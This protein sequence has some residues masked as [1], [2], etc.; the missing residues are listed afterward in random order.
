M[1]NET[2]KIYDAYC[3]VRFN[4]GSLNRYKIDYFADDNEQRY[5]IVKNEDVNIWAKYKILLSYD[6]LSKEIL[7]GDKMWLIPKDVVAN[8]KDLRKL[9]EFKNK[10]ESIDEICMKAAIKLK[11]KGIVYDNKKDIKVCIL[12]T[13]VVRS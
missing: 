9:K 8:T 7:W 1:S 6:V 5:I 12:I 2:C 3:D 10:K 13:D 4:S 11:Y